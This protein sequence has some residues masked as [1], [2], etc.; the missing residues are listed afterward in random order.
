MVDYIE[1]IKKPFSDVKTLIIG[2]ILSIIPIVN[3]LVSGYVL[4]VAEDSIKGK[5]GLREFA[6]EIL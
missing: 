2:I 1:N 4:K 3:L 5:K 6:I